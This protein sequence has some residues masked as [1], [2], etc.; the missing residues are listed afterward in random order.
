MSLGVPENP[1]D[2]TVNSLTMRLSL[3]ILAHFLRMVNMVIRT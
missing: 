2:F 3:G 1:I